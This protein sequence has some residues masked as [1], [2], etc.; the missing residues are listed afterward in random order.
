MPIPG[1]PPGAIYCTGDHDTKHNVCG[2]QL[3]LN[4]DGTVDGETI[5]V[6]TDCENRMPRPA[7]EQDAIYQKPGV[8]M[9]RGTQKAWANTWG[10]E[11][12]TAA[13]KDAPVKCETS[14]GSPKVEDCRLAFDS[15]MQFPELEAR[16][17]KKGK[18]WWAAVGFFF[19]FFSFFSLISG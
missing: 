5:F 10:K 19:F 11:D 1:T 14:S 13:D 2:D 3:R 8:P 9:D 4:S 15:L 7:E 17:G 6:H 12:L 18:T 16:A